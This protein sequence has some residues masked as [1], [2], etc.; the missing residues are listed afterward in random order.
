MLPR[1]FHHAWVIERV[2]VSLPFSQ[3]LPVVKF[4]NG[5]TATVER[6]VFE[7]P[8]GA[9]REQAR[10]HSFVEIRPFSR[11][12]SWTWRRA[13]SSLVLLSPT[14]QTRVVTL[15]ATHVRPS[16]QVPLDLA[17]AMSVHKAQGATLECVEVALEKARATTT[18][19]TRDTLF[20][21]NDEQCL[22]H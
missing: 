12:L 6:A 10:V 11:P 17:W 13:R 20:S 9:T 19:T 4:T 1:S 16:A 22:S 14:K 5:V 15:P 8:G 2:L 3:K 21:P 7:A 18:T